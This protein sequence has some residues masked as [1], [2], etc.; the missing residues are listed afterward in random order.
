MSYYKTK[1]Q[2]I[3]DGLNKESDESS[4]ESLVS[5]VEDPGPQNEEAS[6][7]DSEPSQMEGIQGNNLSEG[8]ELK[9]ELGELKDEIGDLNDGNGA[10]DN[11]ND[12]THQVILPSLLINTTE[13]RDLD[14]TGV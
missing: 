1:I 13:G 7:S 4:D 5:E 12:R 11:N 10:P 3:K 2:D 9:Q 14:M 8:E 6:S